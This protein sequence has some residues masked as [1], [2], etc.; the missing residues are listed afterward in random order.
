[1]SG[2][3]QAT[4][5]LTRR[6]SQA[7]SGA[8]PAAEALGRLG[9]SASELLALPL[10]ERGRPHQPGDRRLR[11]RGR[12]RGGRRPAL[13]RGGLDRHVRDRHR[14]AAPGDPGRARLRRRGLRGRRRPDRARQR[15]DLTA[16]ADLARALEPARRRR[17][18]GARGGGERDGGA[19]PNHR[20]ARD[21][22]PRA[23]RQHRPARDLRRHLRRHHGRALGRRARRRRRLGARSRPRR[24]WSCAAR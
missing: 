20:A 4:K 12:A 1:M 19:R 10:D 24:S 16:R 8:G 2:V 22:D 14:D 18:P 3:E 21:R 6:L 9:L 5:D 17:R 13:R 7:A 23:L 15:R 11:A